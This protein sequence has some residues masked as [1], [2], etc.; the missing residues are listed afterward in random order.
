MH[1][2]DELCGMAACS[3]QMTRPLAARR[4]RIER[5][6]EAV[7]VRHCPAGRGRFTPKAA[8]DKLQR[9]PCPLLARL[10][11]VQLKGLVLVDGAT[12]STRARATKFTK[13]QNV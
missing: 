3:R 9:G 13:R 1:G 10:A 7:C 8:S 5:E 2:C 6:E 12:H 11:D 4:I